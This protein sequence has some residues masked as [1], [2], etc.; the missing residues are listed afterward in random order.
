M[1]FYNSRSA[2]YASRETEDGD[3]AH[4]AAVLAQSASAANN[5]STNNSR[6]PF[7]SRIRRMYLEAA[8]KHEVRFCCFLLVSCRFII[9]TGE[10][11][12]HSSLSLDFS[13][14]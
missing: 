4:L 9:F 10:M 7:S 3:L 6:I 12:T 11:A 5:G 8:L 14:T 2:A 1:L 13:R